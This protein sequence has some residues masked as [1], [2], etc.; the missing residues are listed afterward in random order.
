LR[1]KR[2]SYTPTLRGLSAALSQQKKRLSF[3]FPDYLFFYF[4]KHDEKKETGFS[5][6]APEIILEAFK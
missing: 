5:V 3:L 2:P 1:R 6:V 4:D